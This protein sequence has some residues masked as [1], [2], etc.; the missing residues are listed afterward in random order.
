MIGEVKSISRKS[1]CGRSK[2]LTSQRYW[3]RAVIKTHLRQSL[4]S[5]LSLS[6]WRVQSLSGQA[7]LMCGAG[8]QG[9][10]PS[11]SSRAPACDRACVQPCH[12]P[13]H[14]SY[15]SIH[16]GTLPSTNYKAS[17]AKCSERAT[18]HCRIQKKAV[19]AY[20]NSPHLAVQPGVAQGPEGLAARLSPSKLII[21][22]NWA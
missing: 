6:W 15:P 7:R 14:T 2:T 4:L 19:L 10:R 16:T 20:R 5:S 22:T 3:R 18:N 17:Q 11:C 8:L 21:T 9:S 13:R 1:T 12:P